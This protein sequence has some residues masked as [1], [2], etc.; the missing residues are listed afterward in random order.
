MIKPAN[1]IKDLPTIE[2]EDLQNLPAEE[3]SR[4]R[5]IGCSIL[6]EPTPTFNKAQCEN[7]LDGENNTYIVFGRDRPG[8]LFVSGKYDNGE[9]LGPYGPKGYTK[10]GTIDIVAGRHSAESKDFVEVGN[11]RKSTKV[12]PDFFKDAARIYVSQKTD[13]DSNFKIG[14][15]DKRES[16]GKSAVALK[17]DAIRLI[18]RESIKLVT[19]TDTKNSMGGSIFKTFGIDLVAGNDDSDLQS[20]LKGE[21][22]KE[23]I[24]RLLHHVNALNGIIDAFLTYQMKFNQSVM[25]HT[26]TS[27]FY[28]LSTTPSQTLLVAGRLNSMN[29]QNNVKLSLYK[30]KINLV[31]YKNTYLEPPG[32]KFICSRY[33]KTN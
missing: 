7:I 31:N 20:L 14:S 2:R 4:F 22:T 18:S 10:C 6:V 33:N 8:P 27:P 28:G 5:G 9:N 11:V 16:E 29:M 23:A 21:N 26:H 12:D 30:N 13:V 19:G 1:D 3:R 24:Q 15:K 32:K 17:A 25:L